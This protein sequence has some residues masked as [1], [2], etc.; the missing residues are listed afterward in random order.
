MSQNRGPQLKPGLWKAEQ[1]ALESPNSMVRAFGS[2]T[3]AEE[4]KRELISLAARSGK[5]LPW[6]SALSTS[7]PG[8]CN[9]SLNKLPT[10]TK[11]FYRLMFINQVAYFMLDSGRWSLKSLPSQAF[12]WF[13]D[14]FLYFCFCSPVLFLPCWCDQLSGITAL[15]IL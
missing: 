3:N 5:T 9:N 11:P 8:K 1:M 7:F 13:Y 15:V 2:R 12:L 10:T 4:I 6:V 14:S